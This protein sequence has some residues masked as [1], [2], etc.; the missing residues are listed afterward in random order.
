MKTYQVYIQH[1]VTTMECVEAED[2]KDVIKKFDKR[3]LG[4]DAEECNRNMVL[5]CIADDETGD[6]VWYN[7]DLILEEVE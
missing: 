4:F 3:E 5:D 1:T 2:V 7:K 6:T